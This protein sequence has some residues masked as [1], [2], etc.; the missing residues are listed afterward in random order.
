MKKLLTVLVAVTAI[1][2]GVQT[3]SAAGRCD[4]VITRGEDL[5]RVAANCPPSTTFTIKDGAHKLSGPVDADSGDTFEGSYSDRTR[6]TID[7]NGAPY[8]FDVRGTR[9][10][11]IRGLSVTGAKGGDRC[12]PWC[13]SAIKG[14]GT[15][16]RVL[17]VRL[18]HNPNQGIGNPGDGLLLK[19]SEIDH[20][21]SYSFTSMDGNSG[22]E[23]SSA[24][25]VK[26]TDS[27]ATFTNNEIHDNYWSGIWCDRGGGPIIATGNTIY[28]NGK[29]GIQYETCRGPGSRITNNTVTHNGYLHLHRQGVAV[30]GILLQSPQGVEVAN[31]TLQENREHGIHAIDADR[32]SIFGVEIHHN[33]LGN[34]TLQGCQIS[35]VKCWANGR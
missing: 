30:A 18:H 35:G 1:G 10:V 16:L 24:A 26:I 3:A 2:L 11:T 25:G 20:N 22:K 4:P 7:A 27:T 8:A 15:N 5:N 31:N 29:A 12:E 9:G 17:N 14:D 6:P 21:G 13:G 28:N 33:S 34:D 32:Q 23:P 19:N